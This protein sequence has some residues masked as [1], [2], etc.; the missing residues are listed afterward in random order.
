MR[1]KSLP[2]A[3]TLQRIGG[4]RLAGLQWQAD[5]I[6]PRWHLAEVRGGYVSR[7]DA[8]VVQE[9]SRGL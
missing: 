6:R 4:G 5:F 8:H 1:F 2:F 3:T 9:D 7:K